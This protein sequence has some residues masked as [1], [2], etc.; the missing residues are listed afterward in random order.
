MFNIPAWTIDAPNHRVKFGDHILPLGKLSEVK[1]KAVNL[2]TLVCPPGE[3][4]PVPISPGYWFSTDLDVNYVYVPSE[5]PSYDSSLVPLRSLHH[6]SGLFDN[7]YF[8]VYVANLSDRNIKLHKKTVLGEFLPVLE[9]ET[10]SD[11]SLS[12]IEVSQARVSSPESVN[13]NELT[14][15]Q[16][17]LLKAISLDGCNISEDEKRQL[18]KLLVEYDDIF[19]LQD[20]ELS[21]TD[22]I[23]HKI[24]TLDNDP[25]KTPQYRLPFSLRGELD[26]TTSNLLQNGFIRPSQSSWLSP[27]LFVKKKDG[28]QRFC[29]DLR[30][31]NK[32]TKI[33]NFRLPNI[34]DLL[35]RLADKVYHTSLDCRLGYYQ[36]EIEESDKEKTA[37]CTPSGLYEFNRMPFG[38]TNAPATFARLMCIVLS[39]LS[40]FTSCF[41]DDILVSSSGAFSNHLSDLRSVFD[42][43]RRYKLRLKP[44]KCDFVKPKL[45]YLGHVITRDGIRPG[46]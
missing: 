34:Q 13:L 29:V 19:A 30:K 20:S 45:V 33:D 5:K 42:R 26:K 23:K 38:L 15:H 36:V 11:G 10:I 25:V 17:D 4:I 46:P 37:F 31:V 14:Q 44:S 39:G 22:V 41:L 32:V 43:F 3:C 21:C 2:T 1:F 40:S 35:D 24:D 28:S 9:N 6:A 8:Y 16:E 18:E 7:S 12:E 27:V